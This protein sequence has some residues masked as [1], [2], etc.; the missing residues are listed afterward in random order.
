MSLATFRIRE[1]GVTQSLGA[2]C[3]TRH[4]ETVANAQF[5]FRRKFQGNVDQYPWSGPPTTRCSHHRTV[6]S[7]LN[8]YYDPSTDSFISVDPMVQ[9]TDQP[10]AFVNDNPLNY[11]DALG[12]C[13]LVDG[14]CYVA[15][16]ST[17]A[18]KTV[19]NS[20]KSNA[21]KAATG[22]SSKQ[23]SSIAPSTSTV[24]NI[25]SIA[26]S[27]PGLGVASTV[28]NFFAGASTVS[29]DITDGD[30]VAYTVGDVI[31][32]GLGGLL[33]TSLGV[34]YGMG[35][36]ATLGTEDCGPDVEDIYCL[37]AQSVYWGI[38]GGTAGSYSGS[39]FGGTLFKEIWSFF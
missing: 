3:K 24:N 17:K 15:P 39:R 28:L 33:G 7:I 21:G 4:H 6:E 32:S 19:G 35:K 8:R 11:S 10:Y 23:P 38:A 31:V 26:D 13:A 25:L 29:T 22:S 27:T 2:L 14:H 12:L 20:T 37:P 30:G 1:P 36:G 5:C 9:E 16:S 34:A 18:A